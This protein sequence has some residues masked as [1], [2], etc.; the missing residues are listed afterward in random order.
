MARVGTPPGLGEGGFGDV[1]QA[2]VNFGKMVWGM[3]RLKEIVDNVEGDKLN[4]EKYVKEIGAVCMDMF[5][6]IGAIFG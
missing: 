6:A 4:R 5:R 2:K 1:D 3:V